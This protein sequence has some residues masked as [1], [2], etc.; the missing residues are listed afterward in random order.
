MKS[1]IRDI[2][3]RLGSWIGS[4][5]PKNIYY[6]DIGMEYTKMGTS[7]DVFWSHMSILRAGDVV[8]FD[9]GFRGLWT[10]RER[11]ACIGLRP[12]VFLAIE[13]V[14]KP[15]YLTWSE[16]STLQDDFGFD[17]QCHTWSHQTLVGMYNREIPEPKNGRTE[18]WF[19][20]ELVDSR[21][22]LENRLGKVVSSLCFPVGFFSDDIV[23]RCRDAG[24]ERVYASY[25]GDRSDT[26]IQPRCLAQNL[27]KQQLK[28][29]LRGGMNLLKKH[30]MHLHYFPDGGL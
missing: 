10:S 14:G 12:I 3:L 21:Y 1:A 23:R 29:V 7:E 17:F 9:D 15:R 4:S 2:I 6:H 20:H 24:Y 11:L 19:K 13:L 26:Y 30:Y 25:P 28:F 8:C 16:V 27:T 5:S 22:E 18:E